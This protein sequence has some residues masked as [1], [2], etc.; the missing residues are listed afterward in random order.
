MAA[1]RARG[2]PVFGETCPQYL[3]LS[4]RPA[5]TSPGFDGAKYVMSPP[6][7]DRRAQERLWRGLAVRRAAGGRHRPLPLPDARPEVAGP[8]R[9]HEDPRR[10]AGD[11]DAA[12]PAVRRRRGRRAGST[13]ERFVAVTAAEPGPPLRSLPAQGRHRARLR[14]RHRGLRPGPRDDAAAPRR[15]TCGWTTARTRGA[16]C[17]A[18]RS[19]CSRAGDPSSSGERS[20]A[21]RGRGR[22]CGA[23]RDRPEPG[24][25][26]RRARSLPLVTR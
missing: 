15:S 17:A 25:L 11:R 26:R 23:R 1:A 19:W 13:R 16:W 7:R 3:C 2:L 9:L 12:E 14:C 24:A 8:G 6:L 21:G 22:S 18:R 5:T 10:R 4:R 20:S